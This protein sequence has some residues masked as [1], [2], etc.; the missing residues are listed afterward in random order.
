MV[1]LGREFHGYLLFWEWWAKEHELL[2]EGEALI[3]P[4]YTAIKRPAKR[5]YLSDA[6]FESVGGFCVEKKVF[7][8]YDLPTEL[9]AELKRKAD[10]QET[11]TITINLLELLGMVVTAWVMLE[12]VGDR[13]D[14]AGDLILMRGDNMA[15]VSWVSRSGGATDKRACLLMRML[16]RLE[17]AG[18]W[19][20]TIKH[21]PG[22]QNSLADGVSRWPREMLADKVRELT[23]SSDWREQSIGPRRSG[24]VYTV[25]HIQNT[26]TKHDD[27]LWTLLMT[28]EENA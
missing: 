23:H 22:V 27:V 16:G 26:L 3:A 4:C 2:L 7:W 18:G 20:H 5:H 21:I 9:T 24:I 11:C 10:L 17:L 1:E 13:P 14:A 8:R 12:L 6:S 28:E 15:A 19:N 25:L